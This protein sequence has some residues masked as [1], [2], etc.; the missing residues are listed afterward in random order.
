MAELPPIKFEA[1]NAALLRMAPALVEAWLPGGEVRGLE[2]V[3]HSIWRSE[4]TPSLCVRLEGK[5]AG[6]W[7]DFGGTERGNDLL[8][9][10]AAIH[11][12]SQGEAAVRLAREHRLE[13]VAGLVKGPPGGAPMTPPP[14]P[15]KPAPKVDKGPK[16][17]WSPL[18][19]VPDWVQEVTNFKHHHRQ[20]E[21]IVHVARYGADEQLF[22]YVVRYKRSG[23]GK[24]PLPYVWCQSQDGQQMAWKWRT[25][26][27][28]RPLYLPGGRSI[29]AVRAEREAPP[30]II[31]VEGEV[32]ACVLQELL[33]KHAPGVYVV[34]SWP[35]GSKAWKKALWDWLKGCHVLLWPDCDGKREPLTAAELEQYPD[36]AARAVV[37]TSKPLLPEHKQVGM[38]AMLGI[39][40]M[41]RDLHECDVRLLP[42]PK[43]GE[44]DDGW[45]AADAILT[46]GWDYERV[47]KL[48]AGA[49]ALPPDDDGKPSKKPA[50]PAP[51][52]ADVG[53]GSSGVPP[54]GESGGAGEFDDDDDEFARHLSFLCAELKCD[55]WHLAV[56]RKLII[57]ALRTSKYLAPCLGF[58]ELTGEPGT[59]RPWPWRTA[60]GPMDNAD[61]LRLGDFLSRKYKLKAAS[62]AALQEAIDTVADERRFHPIREWLDTLEHDGT[63]RVDKWLVH[64]LGYKPEQLDAKLLQYFTLVGR[65]VLMGLVARVM[66]PGCKFDYSLVLEGKGGLEKSTFFRR[67]VGDQFF[68]DTHFDIGAGKEGFEQLQGLWGYELSELT[69]LRKADSEQVK[70]FFSSQSDRFRGAYGHYVQAHPRQ[71]VIFCSTNKRQYLYDLSGN[72]RF[73][74]VLA[75]QPLPADWVEKWRAQLFAEALA[76]YRRGERYWPTRDEEEEFFVPEQK[77]R[78]AFTAVQ[79]KLYTLLTRPAGSVSPH[80]LSRD[81]KFVTLDRLTSALGSDAAKSTAVLENQVRSW[82]ESHDWEHGREG[83]G[84]RRYG[85]KR[86]KVWPP[87]EERPADAGDVDGDPPDGGTPAD[88]GLSSPD[89]GEEGQE[90]IG[91]APF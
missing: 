79:S 1:L 71:C 28:P 15:P 54:S 72:R 87:A 88:V 17:E 51:A 91:H 59:Q 44:V 30:T 25:W 27:E 74:P 58:N 82:L 52:P 18:W 69:A 19:P 60:A 42:I 84:L 35:G 34:V 29:N 50:G 10:Y 56:Q 57:K 70:Q 8:S 78:L 11:R 33:D 3:V 65:F 23:G 21:D 22:G 47:Q 43:P 62:K 89:V 16:E 49:Y 26:A 63:P 55:P 7:G 86:P 68:S 90:G 80:E 73:W 75:L 32:K 12:V 45:D 37:Q 53:G 39:G 13:H 40:R 76:R 81:T 36:D 14:P 66:S 48:F 2:Y 20:P 5:R 4:K 64:V 38:V 83:G 77:K 85:F 31:V 24:D 46:D 6:S 41:L 9:L 67:L 61:S